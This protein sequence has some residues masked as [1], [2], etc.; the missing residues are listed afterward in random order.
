MSEISKITLPSGTSYDIKDA[1]ARTDIETIKSSITGGMHY[2]GVTTTALTDGAATN[3]ISIGGTNVTAKSGDIVIYSKKEFI[4]SDS[5]SKWH[6]FGDMGS[7]KALAFKDNA[8]GKITPAGSVSQPTF[9]GD[10]LTSTGKFTPAGSVSI[11]EAE[12]GTA[13]YTPKGTVSKPTFSGTQGTVK[14]SGNDWYLSGASVYD[15]SYSTPDNPTHLYAKT[16]IVPSGTISTPTIT[17]TPTTN[18]TGVTPIT[19]VGTLPNFTTTVSGETLT[20]GWSA[21]TLPEKGSAITVVTGIQ[22]A[23]STQPK[24]TGDTKTMVFE[25]SKMDK[26]YSGKFTPSGSVSQPTFTGTGAVLTASFTGTEGNVSVSGTPTG[27]VSKP[28][29]TGTEGTVTVS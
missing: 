1:A 2:I 20:L 16:E 12:T 11:S 22:S 29:F 7:L 24:F 5:D 9:T 21:G 3:P 28:T 25:S 4:F 13:N 15:G 17:V 8:S 19:S 18:T 6:E 23:T 27:T 26:E 10:N 14:V